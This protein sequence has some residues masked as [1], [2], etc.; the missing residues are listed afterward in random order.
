MGNRSKEQEN[1]SGARN[2]VRIT[3]S[4]IVE[5]TFRMRLLLSMQKDGFEAVCGPR[6]DVSAPGI[7]LRAAEKVVMPVEMRGY[8][9]LRCKPCGHFLPE[10]ARSG[11]GRALADAIKTWYTMFMKERERTTGTDWL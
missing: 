9:V 2:T 11:V 1:F 4:R 8:S 5:V 10:P 7:G 6:R 3:G